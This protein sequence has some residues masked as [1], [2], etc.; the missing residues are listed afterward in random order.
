VAPICFGVRE[1]WYGPDRSFRAGPLVRFYA[2][3]ALYSFG[4]AVWRTK[5]PHSYGRRSVTN[6]V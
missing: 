6:P 4:N 2:R 1:N 3:F 5:V